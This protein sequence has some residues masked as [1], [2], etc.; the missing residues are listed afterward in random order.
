MCVCLQETSIS[1]VLSELT[2]R[3]RLKMKELNVF[4][5]TSS[6]EFNH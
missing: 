6:I 2:N 1:V 3:L 5:G 4:L